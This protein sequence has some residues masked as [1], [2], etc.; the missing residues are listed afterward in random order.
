M[1]VSIFLSRIYHFCDNYLAIHR[2]IPRYQ[3]YA[4]MYRYPILFYV[5]GCGYI[6]VYVMVHAH[7]RIYE[8]K[9]YYD[10]R[11]LCHLRGGVQV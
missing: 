8:V 6:R 4:C 10:E 2:R 3:A 9:Y 7:T 1:R 11:A 5:F